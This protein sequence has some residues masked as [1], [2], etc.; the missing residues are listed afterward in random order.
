VPHGFAVVALE[1]ERRENVFSSVLT[2][3]GVSTTLDAAVVYRPLNGRAHTADREILASLR[4]WVEHLA[5]R[6]GR[7][8]LVDW[9]L[10][11][12]VDPEPAGDPNGPG[13]QWSVSAV[14]DLG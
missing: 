11:P 9:I 8:E 14:F 1:S 5:A 12:D 10:R 13:Q 3:A 7:V 4:A 6:H 2:H